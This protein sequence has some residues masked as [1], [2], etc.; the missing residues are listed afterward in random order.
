MVENNEFCRP[1][2]TCRIFDRVPTV[3]TVGYCQLSLGDKGKAGLLAGHDL[4]VAGRILNP[5]DESIAHSFRLRT[6]KEY[7]PS[8][9]PF[10]KI[11]FG[12]RCY[13]EINFIAA[14]VA[15]VRTSLSLSLGEWDLQPMKRR[16]MSREEGA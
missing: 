16:H 3:E 4:G 1:V 15:M 12:L 2:G 8:A 10:P 11:E 5:N 14:L 6:L 9:I 7:G 13:V